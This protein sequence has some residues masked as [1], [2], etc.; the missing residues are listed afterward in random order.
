MRKPLA[1]RSHVFRRHVAHFVLAPAWELGGGKLGR[2]AAGTRRGVAAHAV[3]NDVERVPASL[4]ARHD[5]QLGAPVRK[6]H[7]C[8][9]RVPRRELRWQQQ[10]PETVVR[11]KGAPG[12]A[13]VGH[14]GR[15]GVQEGKHSRS[16]QRRSH[17]GH[18]SQSAAALQ[19]RVGKA[20][21][22]QCGAA[23]RGLAEGCEQAGHAASAKQPRLTVSAARR[24]TDAAAARAYLAGK[25]SHMMCFGWPSSPTLMP[26]KL[27]TKGCS[28]AQRGCMRRGGGAC[29]AAQ[30]VHDATSPPRALRAKIQP[31][32][33]WRYPPRRSARRPPAGPQET[34]RP[35]RR[36]TV[37]AQR[38][39][40]P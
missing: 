6:Q 18:Q 26:M 10:R 35:P 12:D 36:A 5:V 11:C 27:G 16:V 9:E 37:R 29:A 21:A 32:G 20:R 24:R 33:P 39:W 30:H 15:G 7:R 23:A 31:R 22:A 40:V 2:H 28:G 1:G 8:A 13:A 17:G 38:Q 34:R 19:S 25:Y 14:R 3:E 4:H